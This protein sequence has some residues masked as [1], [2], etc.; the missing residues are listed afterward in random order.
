MLL[1]SHKT[2]ECNIK[3]LS[4]RLYPDKAESLSILCTVQFGFV[5]KYCLA[6]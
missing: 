4:V 6:K 3:A 1:L 2:S 5:S